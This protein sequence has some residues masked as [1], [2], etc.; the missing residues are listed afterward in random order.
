MNNPYYI[1]I[2]LSLLIVCSYLFNLIASKLKVPSVILLLL[3][4]VFINF[5]S[6]DYSTEFKESNFLLEILGIIG[7]ILIVLEGSL[8]LKLSK[9][10]IPLISKSLFSAFLVLI[11]T[12]SL[13]AFIFASL[14]DL[15][16]KTALIYATTLSVISSA[17][18]IPSVTKLSHEKKEFIIYESTFSDILGIMLFNYII[19]DNP[20]SSTSLFHFLIGI[21]L[22]LIIS[23]VSSFLLLFL[24]NYTSSHV[25][26]FL[27]FAILIII[28]SVA[29]L[30][31]LPSLLL[32]MTFGL[33]INNP[34]LIVRGKLEKYFRLETLKHSTKELKL[35]TKESA[36]IVRTFFF[37]LFGYTINLSL[38]FDR[39][40][41]LIGSL[42]I[43]TILLIRFIFL[44]FISK[45]HLIPELFIA[46]RGLITIVL[47]FSIPI[48]YYSDS[49]NQGILFF[50][51]LVSAIIM[52]LALMFTRN[53]YP[54]AYE[55]EN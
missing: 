3:T 16:F 1:L 24:L 45:T 42:I 39:D 26:F 19:L 13:I 23:V 50:V 44:R 20:L 33:M 28:Y 21:A 51:I 11:A 27:I 41:V 18:A 40:V 34:H 31:H 2:A 35:I 8:D 37:I 52:M 7:L 36:F 9:D 43:I 54:I 32:I 10:K 6:K 55:E 5:I 38:L 22:I 17:I 49:F 15:P 29:K 48:Q 12:A 30:F 47:F 25:K 53:E 14:L 46:P 4:G